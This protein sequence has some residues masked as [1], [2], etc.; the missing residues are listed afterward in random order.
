M[1]IHVVRVRQLMQRK[2]RLHRHH[3]ALRIL[4]GVDGFLSK[5][6][7]EAWLAGDSS[8]Q[9]KRERLERLAWHD[10]VQHAKSGGISSTHEVAREQHFLGFANTQLP[11]MIKE[12]GTT[13]PHCHSV[14][15]KRGI[16]ACHDEITRPNEL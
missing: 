2:R 6:E 8:G 13:Y 4:C 7:R 1:Q 11:G 10:M 5:L 15:R 9:F 14:V 16:I 12:L 3:S